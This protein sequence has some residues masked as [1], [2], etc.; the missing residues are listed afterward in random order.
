MQI[1]T[2]EINVSRI[3]RDEGFKYPNK[4]IKLDPESS[5]SSTLGGF[6]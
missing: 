3:K 5:S 2:I 1:E 6:V 4:K